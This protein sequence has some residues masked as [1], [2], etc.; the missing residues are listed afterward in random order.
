MASS[1][2]GGVAT[3]GGGGGKRGQGTQEPGGGAVGATCPH[4]FE[5]VGG[6]PP[7]LNCESLSFFIL[8]VFARLYQEKGAKSGE[9]LV[10]G[11]ASGYLGPRETFAPQL[12]SSSRAHEP[13]NLPPPPQTPIGHPMGRE[14]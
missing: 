5:P 9:F 2:T 8:F 7:T 14:R 11:R 1:Y 10:L 4:N 6:P 12:Q 3:L 13:G